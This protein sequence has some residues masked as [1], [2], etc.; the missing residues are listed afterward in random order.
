MPTVRVDGG[1]PVDTEVVRQEGEALGALW[2]HVT[3]DT[4]F[5]LA[6]T[7]IQK[8]ILPS[9]TLAGWFTGRELEI[10]YIA[11]DG[12]EK[13]TRFPLAGSAEAVRGATGLSTP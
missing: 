7:S 6:W 10:S 1:D 5:W 2:G 13:V 3:R 12:T 4:A 9:D 11:E 8:S